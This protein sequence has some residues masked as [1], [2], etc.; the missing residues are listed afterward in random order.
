LVPVIGFA[1]KSGTSFS[2]NKDDSLKVIAIFPEARKYI[3]AFDKRGVEMMQ[4]IIKI[5]E[6]KTSPHFL[7]YE[8]EATTGI[9]SF[10]T[11]IGNYDAST[12]YYSK[13]MQLA[14]LHKQELLAARANLGFG[15]I[16]DHKA[17]YEKS[18]DKNL[19]ALRYFEKVRD[20]LGIAAA[21]GN[22]GNSYIRLNQYQ[23]AIAALSKAV[24]L[25]TVKGTAVQVANNVA[26]LARAYKGAGNT[27]RELEL[28]L[29]AFSIFQAQGYKKGMATTGSTLG[30][31]YASRNMTDE[32]LKYYDIALKNSWAINDNGNISILY[33]N[34]A[35]LYLRINQANRALLCAD[36]A[37][38]Y[39]K[40][41]GDRLAQADALLSKAVLMH[42]QQKHVEGLA[43][44]KWF[45]ELRDS[46][47]AGDTQSK[48]ADMEVKYDTEKKENQIKLLNIANNNK[49]LELRNSVLLINKKQLQIKDQQQAITINELQIKNQNQKLVNQQLD[50]EKKA[51][52]IKY[53]QE[54]SRIQKLEIANRDLL[55]KKRNYTIGGIAILILAAVLISYLFYNR[56]KA[57]QLVLMQQEKIEQQQQLT[58]AV[59]EAEEK[60]RVRIASDLHDGVGQLFSAVKMNLNGL[61]ERVDMPRDEDRFLAEKT[62]AL[63]E[64]SCKEVRYI[65]HQ[66]MPNMLLRSGI[67]SDV[68]SFIEKIDSEKLKVKV[69]ANG[70]K[71]KLESNVET[72]L[73]RVIQEAVNNVIKHAQATFLNIKLDREAS[74]I[75]ATITDNGVGFDT[76]A[77]ETFGGIG[78]K[79][80]AARVDYLKGTVNYRS[81]P[82]AGTSLR[83]WVP[84]G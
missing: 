79:N 15:I 58:K 56:Y 17:D 24:D 84:V 65:S 83:V 69:E 73:Y 49:S 50:A 7:K 48:I 4:Q 82:G 11:S 34:M 55:I 75:S 46:I 16:A 36:S 10:Y 63:V 76:A 32:A 8:G 12:I 25:Y 66:M 78:L 33:S 31:Y 19:L 5:C 42:T 68:K 13:V 38:Y 62:L 18:I 61:I 23:Q 43:F 22:I 27:Q 74:G 3:S 67:A 26:N 44:T 47:Y 77:V 80:I 54:Q 2:S 28:K 71:D 52:N 72:V 14:T 6:G 45:L 81:A 41:S 40:K 9:A 20:T 21:T 70:F 60:E 53:L 35:D 57:K 30:V 59:I 39:S 37:W 51:Q 1:Q 64:E 29:K